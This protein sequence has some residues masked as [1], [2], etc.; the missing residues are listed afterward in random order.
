MKRWHWWLALLAVGASFWGCWGYGLFDLDEG[1]YAA[2]LS[3]MRQRGDW[4]IPTFDGK[5]FFEK[6]ILMYWGGLAFSSAGVSGELA[7][8]LFSG[9]C[10]LGLAGVV[11]WFVRRRVGETEALFAMLAVGF[12]PLVAGM[13]RM[14]MPDAP[15]L[16]F[17]SLALFSF[18]ESIVGD[19]RWR[20]LSGAS[21]GCAMLAKGPFTSA[22]AVVL[23]VYCV[24]AFKQHRAQ[25]SRGW[26]LPILAYAVVVSAWYV[27]VA[28]KQGSSFF[29]EFVVRQNLGRLAGADEAHLGPPYFY[30]PVVIAICWPYAAAIAS[31]TKNRERSDFERFLWAWCVAVF[32][33]FSIAG[34]KLP[35]YVAPM[36]VPLLVLAAIHLNRQQSKP[37]SVLAGLSAIAGAAVVLA[38]FI[39]VADEGQLDFRTILLSAG[40]PLGLAGL[41]GL[42]S[43]ANWWPV[44][45]S[46]AL[47]MGLCWVGFPDYWRQ[48]HGHVRATA[49]AISARTPSK[50]IEFRMDGMGER[51]ATSHPSLRWYTG[52]GPKEVI[53]PEDL[54]TV[55]RNGSLVLTRRNRLTP[56]TQRSLQDIGLAFTRVGEF[57]EF[58][59]YESRWFSPRAR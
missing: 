45:A 24:F 47:T 58:S 40:I 12:C 38:A 27:P 53:W 57:G 56:S 59:L 55:C 48:S 35:H 17:F 44:A 19:I 16:L 51:L 37:I 33:L 34:S 29:S 36:F 31:A 21:L 7:L 2:A 30:I 14:F 41:C 8:R 13:G 28:V 5:P 3:E 15:L 23:I 42:V 6:P 18:W 54:A 39:L 32:V 20:I 1:I 11:A 4:I 10:M 43:R 22:L 52:I 9:I 50:L 25:L 49:E 46:G 26:M